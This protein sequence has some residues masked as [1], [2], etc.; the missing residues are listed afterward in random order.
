ML[1][2]GIWAFDLLNGNPFA[3]IGTEM[4]QQQ[5]AGACYFSHQVFKLFKNKFLLYLCS[6]ILL[7]LTIF[8]EMK[9]LNFSKVVNFML[10]N[11]SLPDSLN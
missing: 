8:Q 11:L 7:E 4:S 5:L 9:K 1:F 6:L 3:T 10:E 2:N